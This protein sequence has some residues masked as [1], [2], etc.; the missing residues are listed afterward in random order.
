MTILITY[1]ALIA[2]ACV[3]FFVLKG[4]SDARV[5][6]GWVG[7]HLKYGDYDPVITALMYAA[8]FLGSVALV[9][10]NV[11]RLH[12]HG[13]SGWVI[14]AFFVLGWIPF[15]QLISGL[16]SFV[17]LGCSP[18]T[19]GANKYGPDPLAASRL[20]AGRQTGQVPSHAI[21]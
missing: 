5:V 19:V 16:C 7:G 2:V 12:D 20:P 13:V 9:P 4:L 14:V 15:L 1:G 6:R 21:R 8:N 17:W 11:R 18:G 10:V 3:L